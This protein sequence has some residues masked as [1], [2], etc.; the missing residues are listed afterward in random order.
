M[1]RNMRMFAFVLGARLFVIWW[2]T[3]G[4][5]SLFLMLLLGSPELGIG[6][7]CLFFPWVSAAMAI[8]GSVAQYRTFRKL[9]YSMPPEAFQ[10]GFLH[11]SMAESRAKKEL[12][13]ILREELGAVECTM[14]GLEIRALFLPS[15]DCGWWQR[16]VHADEM[17]IAI[18]KPESDQIQGCALEISARPVSRLVYGLL[19]VDLGRNFRRLRKFQE[20]LSLR[21]C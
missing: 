17:I 6:L 18:K 4:L 9:H 20:V 11:V 7:G 2:L 19:W 10:H 12:L 16:L 1:N 14:V 13:D 21:V 15:K 3:T 5:L 8:I